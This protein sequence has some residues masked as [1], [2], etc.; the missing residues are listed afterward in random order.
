[1]PRNGVPVHAA[2]GAGG[3]KLGA[4][5]S[6]RV[7]TRVVLVKHQPAGALGRTVGSGT[8]GAPNS[9]GQRVALFADDPRPRDALPDGGADA[10]A[11]LGEPKRV[12]ELVPSNG[13]DVDA[14]D[15]RHI[16]RR[17]GGPDDLG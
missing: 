4:D 14:V 8:E 6:G 12:L 2:D 10:K 9:R 7:T 11:Q 15:A 16:E 17:G 1:M 5:L 3:R 13:G